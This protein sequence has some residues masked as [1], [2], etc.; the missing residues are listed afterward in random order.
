M[1]TVLHVIPI[2]D[3]T[4]L[5]GILQ[6]QDTALAVR[7]VTN[8][9]K[10][11]S[12]YIP[13]CR[14]FLISSNA[15]MKLLTCD[16]AKPSRESD[17]TFVSTPVR[18]SVDLSRFHVWCGRDKMTEGF[19]VY[20]HRDESACNQDVTRVCVQRA[21][22]HVLDE[23]SVSWCNDESGASFSR[24]GSF[25]VH[26]TVLHACPPFLPLAVRGEP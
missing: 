13:P 11:S 4:V 5:D 18:P 26:A 24:K 17:W 3:G 6:C 21:S 9:K 19:S 23:T 1:G 8:K 10:T 7:L 20:T 2:R 16:C 14:R 12:M 15:S 22:R 25:G